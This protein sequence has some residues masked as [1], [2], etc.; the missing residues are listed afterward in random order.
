MPGILFAIWNS[1][2]RRLS[3]GAASL[4]V[5][6][7]R[8]RDHHVPEYGILGAKYKVAKVIFFGKGLNRRLLILQLET[9]T[10][11]T[12]DCDEWCTNNLLITRRFKLLTR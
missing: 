4:H 12:N 9:V 6:R 1:G 8:G 10:F 7:E 11:V 3:Y 2:D 5:G